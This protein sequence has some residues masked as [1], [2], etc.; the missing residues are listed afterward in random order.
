MKISTY[1]L[2]PRE[3]RLQSIKRLNRDVA[4]WMGIEIM[5][6]TAEFHRVY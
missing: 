3:P 4:R 1:R 6:Q 2:K 5:L